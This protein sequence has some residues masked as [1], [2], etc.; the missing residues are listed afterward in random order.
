MNNIKG[1]ELK[2]RLLKGGVWAVASRFIGIGATLL[3]YALLARLLSPSEM[4]SYFLIMS[5][6]GLFGS[7]VLFGMPQVA[8]K[9]IASS[10][11][12]EDA[13]KVRN[14]IFK[15][16]I[17]VLVSSLLVSLILLVGP[18]QYVFEKL[19]NTDALGNYLGMIGMLIIF[20]SLL[21]L[22]TEFFRG[23]H[24]IR[25]ASIFGG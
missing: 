13:S 21:A 16:T 18:S 11:S 12:F 7:L 23:F 1:N 22:F 2:D 25:L 17:F 5:V 6:V 14:A 8:V 20:T 9:I 15:M 4:G 3:L 19:L 10:T 24:D